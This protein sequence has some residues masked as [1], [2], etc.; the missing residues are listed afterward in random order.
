MS[1]FDHLDAIDDRLS[2]ERARV[3]QARTKRDRDWC[4]HNV[5]MIE[6]ERDSEIAFLKRSSVKFP[7]IGEIMSDDELLAELESAAP[8]VSVL[9]DEGNGVAS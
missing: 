7:T 5:R 3:E 6:Q 4:E 1:D 2:H 8:A 9:G